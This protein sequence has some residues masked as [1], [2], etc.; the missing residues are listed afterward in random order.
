[1]DLKRL[2]GR[3]LTAVEIDPSD[4]NALRLPLLPGDR[5]TWN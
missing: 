2:Y 3:R 1:V 4:L 5:I